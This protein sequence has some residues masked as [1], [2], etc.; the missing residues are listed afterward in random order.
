MEIHFLPILMCAV[1]SIIVGSVWYGV[2]FGKTWARLIGADPECMTDPVK[3][4][5]A[6]KQALPMYGIQFVLSLLQIW[7]LAQFIA[8][9]VSG[10]GLSISIWI[11]LGFIMPSVAGASM[12]NNDSR[13]DNWTKFFLA[14]GFQLILAIAFG[15]IL[16]FWR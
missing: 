14:A 5:A 9:G 2:L 6:N 8:A 3:R 1:L 16:N 11:W 13:K 7:I 12:W 10:A 15:L 4:K